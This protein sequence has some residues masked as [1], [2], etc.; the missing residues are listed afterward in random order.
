MEQ[1]ESDSELLDIFRDAVKDLLFPSEIDAP[2][3]VKVWDKTKG[4]SISTTSILELTG[5]R[6]DD[7]IEQMKLEILFS[8]PTLEQDWHSEEDKQRVKR[9]R[10]LQE[11]INRNLKEVQVYRCGKININVYI[12]GRAS[13]GNIICISTGQLQT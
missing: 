11:A 10:A 9:F 4:T 12:V 2:F 7:Y 1:M 13:S 6:L 3:E 8:T 5:N